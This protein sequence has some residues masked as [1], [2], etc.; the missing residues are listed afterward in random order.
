MACKSIL[1]SDG[2]ACPARC[3]TSHLRYYYYSGVW[4]IVVWKEIVRQSA[5]T[6]FVVGSL[7]LLFGA[8][9]LA[10]GQKS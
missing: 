8:V 9:L 2:I 10:A 4:G 5:I 7:V 3:P 6:V 1:G